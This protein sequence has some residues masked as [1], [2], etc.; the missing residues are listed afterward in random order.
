MDGNEGAAADSSLVNSMPKEKRKTTE[1]GND[2]V[3]G[4]QKDQHVQPRNKTVAVEIED[5]ALWSRATLSKERNKRSK[6]TYGRLV[7]RAGF[8]RSV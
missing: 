3:Q 2:M 6:R 5:N 1:S 7:Y 8:L 4:Y